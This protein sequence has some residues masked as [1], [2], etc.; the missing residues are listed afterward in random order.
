MSTNSRRNSST[1]PSASTSRRNSL[2]SED[3]DFS[4]K[5]NLKKSRPVGTV[6]I[7]FMG[8]PMELTVP[9]QEDVDIYSGISIEG[10]SQAKSKNTWV[11]MFDMIDYTM[12]NI[13]AQNKELKRQV[14]ELSSKLNKVLFHSNKEN[15]K[16]QE[17]H[18]EKKEVKKDPG[19][20]QVT[21][22]INKKVDSKINKIEENIMMWIDEETTTMK[23]NIENDITKLREDV[24]QKNIDV[25]AKVQATVDTLREEV[26]EQIAIIDNKVEDTMYNTENNIP[27]EEGQDLSPAPNRLIA[28]LRDKLHRNSNL[29]RFLISEPLS[30]QFSIS[31]KEDFHATD[32]E[33]GMGQLLPFNRVKCNMGGAVE[34]EASSLTVDLVRI[35]HSGSWLLSLGGQGKTDGLA[36]RRNDHAK[37][38]REKIL[39][40]GRTDVVQ[41]KEDDILRVWVSV[42]HKVKEV[43]FMG[44]LLRPKQ[45]IAPGST[46]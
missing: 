43:T 4:L 21:K 23:T 9:M 20:A 5:Q 46:M 14:N 2:T 40:S 44:L 36:V 22:E 32:D 18:E 6:K 35:P 17:N 42:G 39:E 15:G 31:R 11:E 16:I 29:L 33:R 3:G 41:L 30:C 37:N 25:N 27:M 1:V 34:D 28:E 8:K 45:F 12:S 26:Q 19:S 38:D 10:S 7:T 24:D 13:V